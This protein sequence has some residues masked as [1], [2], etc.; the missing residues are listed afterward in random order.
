MG[1]IYA[2]IALISYL[3]LPWT[4]L[5]VV[6]SIDLP[7]LGVSVDYTKAGLDVERMKFF[8]W[9][10]GLIQM[11]LGFAKGSSPK[12]SKRRACFNL[13]QVLGGGVYMYVIRYTGISKVPIE[14]IGFGMIVVD[15]STFMYLLFGI[16]CMNVLLNIFDVI[17]A[18]K[19]QKSGAVYSLD[20]EWLEKKRGATIS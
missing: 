12:R 17:I 11:G 18:I 4:A 20:K 2:V 1:I 6:D 13:L 15:F 19:D 10:L 14:L 3:L 9:G 8:I 7:A 5:E 16:V